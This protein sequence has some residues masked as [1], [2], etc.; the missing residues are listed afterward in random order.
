MKVSKLIAWEF[1]SIG[2]FKFQTYGASKRNQDLHG[3]ATGHSGKS[4]AGGLLR[5]CSGTWICGYTCKISL[6]AYKLSFGLASN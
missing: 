5:D 1:P 4:G 2:C 6:R 3:A